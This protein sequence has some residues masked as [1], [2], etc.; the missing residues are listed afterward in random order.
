MSMRGSLGF[1]MKRA[2]AGQSSSAIASVVRCHPPLCRARAEKSFSCSPI[3]AIAALT[4]PRS[5]PS[6]AALRRMSMSSRSYP[7]RRR[8]IRGRP[9][10]CSPPMRRNS[11]AAACS[12]V[13]SIPAL[14]RR[15]VPASCV[16]MAAGTSGR[17]TVCSRSSSAVPAGRNG[18]RCRHPRSRYPRR[19][20][21]A[22]GSQGLL[23]GWPAVLHRR[24]GKGSPRLRAG[25]TGQTISVRSFILM[26][27]VT[28]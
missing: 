24:A 20:M 22:T 25:P 14:A 5:R 27:S 4:S 7:T 18:G 6:C 19:F 3:T 21:A 2:G 15:A 28:R 23:L 1:P 11:R 16:R 12:C 10:I 13:W 17:T 8:I 26:G 9:H